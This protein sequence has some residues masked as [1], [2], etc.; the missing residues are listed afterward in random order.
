MVHLAVGLRL[1]QKAGHAARVVHAHQA[2]ALGRLAVDRHGRDRH[3]GIAIARCVSIIS[4]KFI[5]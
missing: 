5:R 2:H 3:V 1:F 4:L